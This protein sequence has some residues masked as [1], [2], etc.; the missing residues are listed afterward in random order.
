VKKKDLPSEVELSRGVSEVFVGDGITRRGRIVVEPAKMSA[1]DRRKYY[2]APGNRI[3]LNGFEERIAAMEQGA[4]KFLEAAGLPVDPVAKVCYTR[5]GIE[6]QGN[7][8]SAV[9]DEERLTL[10]WYSAKFL[11][12]LRIARGA[13]ERGDAELA[14]DMG[15]T[16]GELATEIRIQF[17]YFTLTGADGGK[18][19]KKIPPLQ[20]WADQT[21][22]Q[23]P[24][25]KEPYFW[26]SIPGDEP[27]DKPEP[28]GGAKMIR[29][30]DKLK[31]IF[32]DGKFR[33]LARRSF[34][35]YIARARK[36]LKK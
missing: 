33:P 30:G 29:D 13:I 19:E 20:N 10:K 36:S 32:P 18:A 8:L 15:L 25:E 12:D 4:K 3:A 1:K 16:L 23:Y 14:A 24:D 17:G 5:D 27:G 9:E 21:V 28:I 31:V 34:K 11:N 7:T 6:W 26:N 35:R 2:G 22:R